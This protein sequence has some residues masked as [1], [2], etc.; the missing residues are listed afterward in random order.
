MSIF[1][2]MVGLASLTVAGFLF[3]LVEKNDLC[4]F[5]RLFGGWWL[6]AGSIPGD[7][8]PFAFIMFKADVINDDTYV[9]IVQDLV[10]YYL[11]HF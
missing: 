3:L 8:L 5:I 2:S 7:E 1:S 11:R 10:I 6:V 9:L 4:V